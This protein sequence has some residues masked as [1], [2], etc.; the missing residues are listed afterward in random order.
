[1][2]KPELDVDTKQIRRFL[3]VADEGSF[4][5]AAERLHVSQSSL[6]RAIAVIEQATKVKL[7]ERTTRKVS[8]TEE[9]KRVKEDLQRWLRDLDEIFHVN[10]GSGTLC[11]GFNWILPDVWIDYTLRNFEASTNARVEFHRRDTRYAGVESGDVDVAVV[12][13]PLGVSSMQS[14]PMFREQSVL[15]VRKDSP[16]A[17]RTR[18]PWAEVAQHPLVVNEV[19]GTTRLTEW[20]TGKQPT[21]SA[22]CRN[23]DEW[24]ELIA[25]GRGVGVTTRSVPRHLSHPM[26]RFLPLDATPKVPVYVMYSRRGIHPLIDRFI[27]AAEQAVGQMRS[28]A[29]P[30]DDLARSGPRRQVVER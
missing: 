27:R 15:A 11:L 18:V 16:L 5:R 9:G 6:T 29:N 20:P 2:F 14:L 3:A 25:A 1:M 8:L 19:S 30:V 26:I 12:R 7:L 10:D 21:V 13:G 24:I 28:A 22:R 4:T 17:L 23:L